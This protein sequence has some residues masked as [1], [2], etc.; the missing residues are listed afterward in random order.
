MASRLT[1]ES[2]PERVNVGDFIDNLLEKL[3]N[4]GF[5]LFLLGCEKKTVMRTQVE[6]MKKY[7]RITICGHHH[8][9]FRKKQ[10]SDV[11]DQIRKAFPDI[12]LVGMGV[13]IQ[14]YFIANNWDLLP[15]AVYMGI[16]GVFYYIAGLKTRAP[17]WMRDYSLEWLF[18]LFQ[19]PER[20]WKRYTV[21]NLLFIS[22]IIKYFLNDLFSSPLKSKNN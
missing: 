8:G 14:E 6:I 10:E 20:L 1:K 18:R 15:N 9:F 4:R 19:E 5:R 21:I 3:D 13:P 7:Q 11:V 12:V 2:L 17:N 16:G 22:F